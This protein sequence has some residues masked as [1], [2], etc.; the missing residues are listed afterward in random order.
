MTLTFTAAN[1]ADI[2]M[3]RELAH[4]IW[5]ACYPGIISAAQIDYMLARFFDETALR[6]DFAAGV[7]WEIARLDAQPVGFLACVP[8][9]AT[10]RLK[11]SKLYLLPEFHGRGLGQQMLA[12]V[13][14]IAQ[15]THARAIHLTVNKANTKAI[16]AYE[17]AGYQQTDSQVLDI[18]G[19]YVMDDYI[20]TLA[21]VAR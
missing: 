7:I 8:D 3:L 10:E 4:R 20:M 17:R 11:L 14:A 16:R 2:P 5:H 21:P 19:G 6:Q 15:R 9:V 12:R 1:I 13:T 18:G